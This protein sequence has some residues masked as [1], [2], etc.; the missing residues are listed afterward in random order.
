LSW[1]TGQQP[2]NA[3]LV[4]VTHVNGQVDLPSDV[5]T[6]LRMMFNAVDEDMERL[7]RSGDT[8]LL[9]GPVDASFQV[10]AHQTAGGD[11][12]GAAERRQAVGLR[13]KALD[14]LLLVCG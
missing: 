4:Y 3:K 7:K 6:G 13:R 1:Q 11:T 14:T 2:G 12:M 5:D 10:A 9:T 8:A